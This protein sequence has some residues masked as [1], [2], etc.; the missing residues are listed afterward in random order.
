MN[1]VYYLYVEPKK[2]Q[3]MSLSTKQKETHGHTEQTCGCQGGGSL[4]KGW[5]R[6]LELQVQTHIYRMDKQDPSLLHRKL[7]SLSYD[8]P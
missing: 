4:K 2:S 6:G 3:K 8:K 7:Y 5:I 1:T